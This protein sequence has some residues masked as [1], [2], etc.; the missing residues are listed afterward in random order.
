[1]STSDPS[2]VINIEDS[3]GRLDRVKVKKSEMLSIITTFL[4]LFVR[5]RFLLVEE[6]IKR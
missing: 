1:M 4:F 5:F 2:T 3:N 6:V